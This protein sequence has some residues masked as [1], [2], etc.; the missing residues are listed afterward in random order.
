[1]RE[2]GK[3]GEYLISPERETSFLSRKKNESGDPSNHLSG[4][5]RA[6]PQISFKPSSV[7][8]EKFK[9]EGDIFTIGGRPR[10]TSNSR[11][12]RGEQRG[13]SSTLKAHLLKDSGD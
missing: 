4:G 13:L 7:V 8:R 9:G 1:L 5:I 2:G 3:W 11:G 12:E 6:L 10:L